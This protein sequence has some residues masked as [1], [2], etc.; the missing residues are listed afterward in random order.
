MRWIPIILLAFKWKSARL[1][2]LFERA[3]KPSHPDAPISKRPP[4]LT[5]TNNAGDLVGPPPVTREIN[6]PKAYRGKT[7]GSHMKF[8]H[9][10]DLNLP[11]LLRKAGLP[12]NQLAFGGNWCVLLWSKKTLIGCYNEFL[13]ILFLST[14]LKKID[15]WITY[16]WMSHHNYSTSK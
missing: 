1:F 12:L 14:L 3:T 15:I 4:S 6:S 13:F 2:L 10:Q 11:P 9:K 16:L 8:C 5:V 7:T